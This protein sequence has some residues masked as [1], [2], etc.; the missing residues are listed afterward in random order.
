MDPL[1]QILKRLTDNQVEYVL[2]GGMAAVLHGSPVVTRDV[3]VCA[4]LEL[5]NLE[6]IVWA[7]QGLNPRFRF[8]PDK[9]PLFDDPARLVGFSNIN[10]ITDWGVIDILGDVPGVGAYRE[11]VPRSQEVQIS[12][13]R[14]RLL[15]LDALIVAK[16]AAGRE[17][18]LIGVRHLEIIKRHRDQNPGLFDDIK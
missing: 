2:V 8:R 14:C 7:L 6:R 1:F 17:K 18:D 11:L 15:D 3:D 5:P 9:M 12:D 4:P 16:R 10:L 13:F